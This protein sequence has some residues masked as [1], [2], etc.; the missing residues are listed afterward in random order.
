[1]YLPSVPSPAI[2]DHL[3]TTYFNDLWNAA[4]ESGRRNFELIKVSDTVSIGSV[5]IN[6]SVVGLPTTGTVY[7]AYQIPAS[8]LGRF[9]SLYNRTWTSDKEILDKMG[10]QITTYT[11]GGRSCPIGTVWMY[12]DPVH[13]SVLI[14]I[15]YL[16]LN[17]CVGEFYPNIYMTLYRDPTR[18]SPIIS[19]YYKVSTAFGAT[20]TPSFVSSKIAEARITY[21]NGTFVYVNGFVY[22]P[23]NVPTLVNGDVVSIISDPDIV[24]Y[25]DIS[26][27]DDITG[28]YSTKYGE[29]REVLHI[30]KSVNPDNVVLTDNNIDAIV[31]DPQTNKGVYG[32]RADQ[33]AITSITHNDFSTSRTSLQAFQNELGSSSVVVRLYV[34]FPSR[35]VFLSDEINRIVDLYSLTDDKIQKQ[36]TNRSPDQI[37]EWFA[38][39]L[40]QSEFLTLL[41]RFK[42]FD[43]TEILQK[44]IEAMGYHDVASTLA[45]S[46]VRYPYPKSRVTI[47]KPVRL[48][49]NLCDV[50][51]YSDGRKIPNSAVT[52]RNISNTEFDVAFSYVDF[53]SEN[54]DILLYIT[55]IDPSTPVLID[56]TGF[57]LE[58]DMNDDDYDIFEIINYV[59]P[60]NIWESTTTKGFRYIQK[61]S[62]TYTITQNSNGTFKY[63]LRDSLNNKQFYFV[64]KYGKRNFEFNIDSLLT[65]GSP[66]I[67]N[68]TM[69]DGDLNVLPLFGYTTAEI[70]INGY[71]LIPGI[72]F[73]IKKVM[74]VNDDILQNLLIIS[75][76][77]FI[78]FQNTNNLVEV[79]THGDEVV[80]YDI[81]YAVD[82]K[83]F[84][85]SGFTYWSNVCG[86][87]F[88]DGKVL[89]PTLRSGALMSTPTDVRD[90][91]PF[92]VEFMI[93]YGVRKLLKDFSPNEDTT[94]EQRIRNVLG[95]QTYTGPEIIQSDHLYALY[96][97]FISQVAKDVVSGAFVIADDP[98]ADDFL[99]QFHPYD[100]IRYS[101]PTIGSSN[102][103]LDRRFVTLAANYK[104]EAVTNLQQ[105]LLI[106]RLINLLMETTVLTIEDVFI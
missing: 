79:I 20:Y 33:N 72:D 46:I 75:N 100:I 57:N 59:T 73:E 52:V 102:T 70:Y 104:N 4:D 71:R 31:Y 91:A 66:I 60:Q 14:A 92:Y 64:P 37:G 55:E 85:T 69:T 47:A 26:V 63:T 36:L 34:R 42:G 97:P 54:S 62:F 39:N 8:F 103:L 76:C 99:R 41:Y 86:R 87:A 95:N 19:N 93:P 18:S 5:Y 43:K 53:V 25:T 98:S 17:R 74:G 6:E 88:V 106:R 15:D 84:L 38:A 13:Y 23:T 96:S 9:I 35:S 80:S 16:T 56:T 89:G 7:A 44:F 67:I 24:G 22:F 10:V 21:P 58:I 61:S 11:V 2:V 12:Y 94:L 105:L 90:G 32:H 50:I 45:Q 81:G 65:N 101:D 30:S 48:I 82:N 29:Y 83:L 68:L 28:Y 27:D 49:G 78:N 40:E 51:A 3:N 1:M 77:D